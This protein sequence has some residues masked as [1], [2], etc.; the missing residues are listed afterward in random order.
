M[1]L[2]VREAARFL[3]VDEATLYRWVRRG[4]I[5]AQQVHDQYRFDRI[6][7][8]EFASTRGIP[9]APEVLSDSPPGQPM[10]R[11]ADAVRAGG[12][13]LDIPAGDKASVLR[14]VV[15][16]LPVPAGLDRDFLYQML[17]AR[18]Q[19]GS[20]GLGNGIALPHPRNPI[21]LRVAAPSVAVC[22]LTAP[23]DFD[24]L[25][26]KPVHTLFT[27]VSPSVRVHL[28]L[29]AVLAAALHDGAIVGAITRRAGEAELVTELERVEAALAA[30]RG[31]AS[32]G[33]PA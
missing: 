31:G 26:G 17:L 24:A 13:H 5:R 20:T 18:E 22:Y 25:D 9:V 7:L 1:Q 29:L 23:V 21:V 11:L 28:H 12:V 30:R 33:E 16:R 2:D 8:L 6:D 19:M 15:D 27:V 4:E 32:K 14:A 10:P 3:G